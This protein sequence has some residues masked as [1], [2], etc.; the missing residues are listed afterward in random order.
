MWPLSCS[1]DFMALVGIYNYVNMTAP[2]LIVAIFKENRNS[3]VHITTN[4]CIVRSDEGKK[5]SFSM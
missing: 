1:T 2:I 5:K 3:F 4:S